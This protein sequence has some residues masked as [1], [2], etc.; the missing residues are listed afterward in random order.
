MARWRDEPRRQALR[1]AAW[2]AP[3]QAAW[4]CAT[5]EG[6][7]LFDEAGPAG[8]WSQPACRQRMN[9]YGRWLG[10]LDRTGRLRTGEGPAARADRENIA[11][12]LEALTQDCAPVTVRNYVRDLAVMLDV[13][14][15]ETDHAWLHR[16][17]ARLRARMRPVIDR[18]RRLRPVGVLYQAGLAAMA[19]ALSA[20]AVIIVHHRGGNRRLLRETAYRDGLV[21]ALLAACPLRL[22]SLVALAPGAGSWSATPTATACSSGLRT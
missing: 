4:A 5:A 10:F 12:Y 18:E 1:P 21:L 17:A 22:R 14:A 9:A 8:R 19:E 13:L 7:D 3:D 16:L 11:A 20:P 6:Q 15:P 2:P